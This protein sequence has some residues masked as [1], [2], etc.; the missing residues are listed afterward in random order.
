MVPHPIPG[1]NVKVLF[2]GE[3]ICKT[4]F[5]FYKKMKNGSDM[6]CILYIFYMLDMFSF[7]AVGSVLVMFGD[8]SAIRWR[9]LGMC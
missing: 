9:C 6:I 4:F 5:D 7:R 3:Q 8:A 1:V 2:W